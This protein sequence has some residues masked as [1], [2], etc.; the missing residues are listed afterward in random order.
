DHGDTAACASLKQVICSG[1][2]LPA[3]LAAAFFR[4]LP[5]VGLHN[6]YGPT[7]AAVDVTA[8]ACVAGDDASSIPIGRPV[9]NTRIYILD[10]YGQPVPVGVAGEI[11]I[12]GVQ[13]GRGYLNRETLTAERFLPDP[14]AHD[15][16]ARMYKTGDLGRW[17]AD[18]NI[19]YLGRND[20]QVK[21]RGFRIELGEIET[22]LLRHEQ[23]Q[24]A[25]VI[26]RE[27][28]SGEKRLVAYVVAGE[29]AGTSEAVSV[30][31]LRE[32]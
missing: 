18:G 30:E 27:D 23:I 14:F 16:D 20:H 8:W 9:A 4:Q 10:G 2:A 11:F 5:G 1:E 21:I 29:A 13:V 22:Q 24:E 15:A 32:Y 28:V 3:V 12:G 26:A 19:E 17:R 25:V 6:L 31:R 7:E